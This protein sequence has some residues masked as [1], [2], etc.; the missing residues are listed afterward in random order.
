M[1]STWPLLSLCIWLPILGGAIV[2][3][4]G[5]R[6]NVARW[7]ALAVSIVVFVVSIPLWTGYDASAGTMQFTESLQWIPAINAN[8]HLGDPQRDHLRH[9]VGP[10]TTRCGRYGH[11]KSHAGDPH[12]PVGGDLDLYR[13]HTL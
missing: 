1:N 9:A 12:Q 13:R 11:G 8:Y 5:E 7:L 3:L 2:A 10:N 6:A 4:A